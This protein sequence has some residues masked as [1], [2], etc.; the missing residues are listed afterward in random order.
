[1]IVTWLS[2]RGSFSGQTSGAVINFLDRVFLR[3]HVLRCRFMKTIT[4][5]F[6]V[7]SGR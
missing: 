1:M 5:R 2:L 3:A 7:D 6:T 4:A